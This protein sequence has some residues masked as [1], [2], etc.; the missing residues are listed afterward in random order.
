MIHLFIEYV[1]IYID[2]F[3]KS[4][5]IILFRYIYFYAHL[6][7]CMF[8]T[9]FLNI[10]MSNYMF[11]MYM[12]IYILVLILE[13]QTR[14]SHKTCVSQRWHQTSPTDRWEAHQSRLLKDAPETVPCWIFLAAHV[15]G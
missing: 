2:N 8:Y 12:Y 13:Q 3:V 9:H 5:N 11:L 15:Q 6:D 4:I 10:H 7:I 14:R 1:Y